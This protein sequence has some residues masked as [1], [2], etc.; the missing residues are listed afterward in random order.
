MAKRNSVFYPLHLSRV[1]NTEQTQNRLISISLTTPFLTRL[2]SKTFPSY[3]ET[4]P[5]DLDLCQASDCWGNINS[6]RYSTSP[7]TDNSDW[8]R[9]RSWS[10]SSE[11]ISCDLDKQKFQIYKQQR[12]IP[13]F[14][15]PIHQWWIEATYENIYENTGMRKQ[16]WALP[17]YFKPLLKWWHCS[18][19]FKHFHPQG[20]PDQYQYLGNCPPTPLLTQH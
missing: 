17:A 15:Q 16:Q 3:L 8:T 18:I 13:S 14:S 4:K 10:S 9:G 6:G 12:P 11:T 5:P 2:T 20:W 19:S 7:S 1:N